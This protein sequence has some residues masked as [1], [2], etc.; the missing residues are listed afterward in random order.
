MKSIIFWDMTPCSLLSC[1]QRFGGTYRLHL[2]GRR[3]NSARTSKLV[4]P[5]RRCQ[6]NRLHGVISQKMILFIRQY[7]SCFEVKWHLRLET[8]NTESVS[9]QIK[10]RA[11]RATFVEK[12]CSPHFFNILHSLSIFFFCLLTLILQIWQ[13]TP[14]PNHLL[15]RTKAFY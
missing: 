4:P 10:H 11:K 2:Q 8:L 3:N 15:H 13:S 5:K 7:A 12:C 6:L 14:I 9:Q 1:N